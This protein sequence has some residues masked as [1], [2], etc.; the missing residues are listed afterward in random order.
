MSLEFER[1]GDLAILTLDR[2]KALN[3][4]SFALVAELAARFADRSPMS[5]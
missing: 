4:L 3:A 1:R 2:P 5:F